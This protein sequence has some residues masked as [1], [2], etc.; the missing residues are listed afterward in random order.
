MSIFKENDDIKL[1]LSLWQLKFQFVIFIHWNLVHGY[2]NRG[3]N[4]RLTLKATESWLIF[5]FYFFLTV[6]LPYSLHHYY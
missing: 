4:P 3:K 5:K 2:A 6:T 1:I